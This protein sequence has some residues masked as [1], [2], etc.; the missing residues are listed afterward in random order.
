MYASEKATVIYNTCPSPYFSFN[1]L[2]QVLAFLFCVYDLLT[3][4]VPL[5]ILLFTD[6]SIIF[7]YTPAMRND[8]C[9]NCNTR[10]ISKTIIKISMVANN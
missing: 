5:L 9:I 3:G 2:T 8:L 7:A 10:N 4:D 1:N 6:G